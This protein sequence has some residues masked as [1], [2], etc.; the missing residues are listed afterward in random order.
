MILM[1]FLMLI[2]LCL[3]HFGLGARANLIVAIIL[4]VIGAILVFSG[5]DGGFSIRARAD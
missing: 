5:W 1:L 2:A 4:V 3:G